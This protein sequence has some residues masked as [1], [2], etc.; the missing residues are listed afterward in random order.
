MFKFKDKAFDN[1]CLTTFGGAGSFSAEDRT[2]LEALRLESAEDIGEL[3]LFENLRHLTLI[4]CR[5]NDQSSLSQLQQL[6]TLTIR[7]SSLESAAFISELSNLESVEISFTNLTDCEPLL[8][9]RNIQKI[10]LF[11]NPLDETSYNLLQSTLIEQARGER[12]RPQILTFS[13]YH[14]WT[15]L[16]KIRAHGLAVCADNI[17]GFDIIV[18]PHPPKYTKAACDFVLETEITIDALLYTLTNY[19]VSEAQLFEQV[20][21]QTDRESN[22]R[23]FDFDNRLQ[24]G[25]SA[26]VQRWIA[27]VSLPPVT[28]TAVLDF[29]DR[30]PNLTFTKKA[31]QTN[32][33]NT[34]L[35][36]W[37][38]QIDQVFFGMYAPH[39][40]WMQF[41]EDLDDLLG[42]AGRWYRWNRIDFSDR[43][44]FNKSGEAISPFVIAIEQLDGYQ[45]AINVADRSDERLYLF[46]LHEEI[47][48][49]PSK[50]PVVFDRYAD[51]INQVIA[52]R[53]DLQNSEGKTVTVNNNL[54]ALYPSTHKDYNWNRY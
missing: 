25:F 33:T 26:D 31:P 3:K 53:I 36:E 18:R 43:Q 49:D 2:G 27:D 52:I 24:S 44:L 41:N 10:T 35:P 40:V 54:E 50:L 45:I 48:T 37:L 32:Q 34:Q 20:I 17:N 21:S 7:C 5:L 11:G 51:M 46:D 6:R 15:R 1:A 8:R 9:A 4:G 29:I 14:N 13:D 30:F 38:R 39:P 19:S 16:T 28:K 23:T 22:E 42:I 47:L 12:S